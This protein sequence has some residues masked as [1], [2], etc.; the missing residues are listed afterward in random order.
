MDH[1]KGT[2]KS[3]DNSWKIYLLHVL[4][5]FNHLVYPRSKCS[6]NISLANTSSI[7]LKPGDNLSFVKKV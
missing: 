7:L 1:L 5:L 6:L 4:K 3:L 2:L